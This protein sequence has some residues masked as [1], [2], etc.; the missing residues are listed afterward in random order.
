MFYLSAL[1][2]F[3]KQLKRRSH[4]EEGKEAVIPHPESVPTPYSLS[5][6]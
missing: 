5:M 3:S 4:K 2:D 1:S 6:E